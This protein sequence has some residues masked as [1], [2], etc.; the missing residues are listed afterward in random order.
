MAALLTRDCNQ[1]PTVLVV[2]DE[3]NIRGFVAANLK[4]RGYAVLQASNAE[5]GLQQLRDYGAEALILDIR[6]PGMSGWDMLKQIAADPRLPDIPV[7]ILT[8]SALS[9]QPSEVVYPNVAAILI[10]PI[11]VTELMLAVKEIFGQ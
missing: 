8:A 5:D 3:A 2:E 4:A 6:L 10:K 11:G 9:T 7:I 1:M